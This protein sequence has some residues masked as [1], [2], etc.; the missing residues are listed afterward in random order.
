MLQSHIFSSHQLR[1]NADDCVYPSTC[2]SLNVPVRELPEP[3][4]DWAAFERRVSA[5]NDALPMVWNP[6]KNKMTRWIDMFAL[7]RQYGKKGGCQIA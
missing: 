1:S 7:K 3:A 5:L 2:D 4:V 6:V